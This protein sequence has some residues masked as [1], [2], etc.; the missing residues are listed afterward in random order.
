[1]TMNDEMKE[2]GRR[3]SRPL[4]RQGETTKILSLHIQFPGW[5]RILE[6]SNVK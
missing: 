4:E 5:F 1:M 3:R 6:V 2:C